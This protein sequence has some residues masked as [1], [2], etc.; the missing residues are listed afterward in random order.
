MQDLTVDLE[1]GIMTSGGDIDA[2]LTQILG[3]LASYNPPLQRLQ[4]YFDNDELDPVNESDDQLATVIPNETTYEDLQGDNKTG[5]VSN[6]G[7]IDE[8]VLPESATL[9][10]GPVLRRG[11]QHRISTETSVNHRSLSKLRVTLTAYVKAIW[12]QMYSSKTTGE[13]RLDVKFGSWESAPVA[14]E[15]IWWFEVFPHQRDDMVGQCDV[16]VHKKS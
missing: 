2:H 12:S 5:Q 6:E 9:P 11:R 16:I 4:I 3:E 10:N 15:T 13:R 7:T 14:G 8:H 1:H